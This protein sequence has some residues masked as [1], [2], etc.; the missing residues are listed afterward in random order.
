MIKKN[1][2]IILIFALLAF[3]LYFGN[4]RVS[5]WDQDEAAYAG[6]G[7]RMIETENY[8]IPQFTWSDVHRKPPLH[9]WLI[10]VSYRIFGYGEFAVRFF[11]SLAI[12][13]V[14]LLIFFY[15]KKLFTQKEALIASI[16]LGTSLFVP[17]LGKMAVTDGLLLFFHTLAAFSLIEVLLTKNFWQ[18]LLFWFAISM[19]ALVK[20]PPI[21]IFAG[22]MIILLFIFSKN[23]LNLIKLHPW[24][25]G[26][27]ALVPL[28]LWGNAAWQK[29]GGTFVKWLIDWYILKRV[30]ESV[31]SQ[32]GPPG[33]YL[34]S[35]IVFFIP[36]LAF[37]PIA[38]INSF[39][40]FKNKESNN[41]LLFIWLISGWIFFEI[42][43]SKLPA[44]VVAVYPALALL[45]SLEINKF[46]KSETKNKTITISTIVQ[47][48]ISLILLIAGVWISINILPKDWNLFSKYIIIIIFAMF[49]AGSVYSLSLLTKSKFEKFTKVIIINA[50]VFTTLTF[51]VLLPAVDRIKN[52]TKRVAQYIQ[53]NENVE[54]VVICNKYAAPPSLPYYIEILNPEK[55]IEETYYMPSIIE[56][57]N[58]DTV[59]AFVLSEGQMLELQKTF[60]RMNLAE[61]RSFS[62]AKSGKQDYFITINK[63]NCQ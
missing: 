5:L 22:F 42:L 52:S 38:I 3:I 4:D 24:I 9:F 30:N 11:S 18:V 16:V 1:I 7:K 62:T 19:G 23:R 55:K 32:T 51:T 50:F 53:Q 41:F 57:Y 15:G 21:L 44:Y 35:Y 58:S 49:F 20:G 56:K 26:F 6:F 33:Y 8:V 12:F 40:S 47:V 43:K 34:A 37:L 25:F 45:I 60:P 54:R 17:M 63:C 48:V 61:I 46:S 29:D 13:G 36:Y 10:T 14:Y 28:Y 27:V 2:Y 31:F 39:K 59:Y